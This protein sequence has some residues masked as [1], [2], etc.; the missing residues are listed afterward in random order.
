MILRLYLGH[1]K[2]TF[3]IGQVEQVIGVN[4]GIKGGG[5]ILMWDFD[6]STLKQV[7]SELLRI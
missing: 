7:I 5:H 1:F 3:T 2:F 6:N 4:S